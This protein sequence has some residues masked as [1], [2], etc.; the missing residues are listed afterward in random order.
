M[1]R[2]LL[3]ITHFF[4]GG[5]FV[6]FLSAIAV[7]RCKSCLNCSRKIALGEKNCAGESLLFASCYHAALAAIARCWLGVSFLSFGAIFKF[8]K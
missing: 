5:C 8:T 6:L 3:D 7:V 2:E 1:L 4:I